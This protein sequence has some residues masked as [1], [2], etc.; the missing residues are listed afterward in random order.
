MGRVIVLHLARMVLVTTAGVVLAPVALGAEQAGAVDG[1]SILRNA[2]SDSNEVWI[3]P[4]A[5]RDSI[6]TFWQGL[7]DTWLQPMPDDLFDFGL[8]QVTIDSLTTVG[9]QVVADMLAG[10]LWKFSFHPLRRFAFNRVEGLRPG[11]LVRL[12]KLGRHRPELALGLGYG[13]ASDRLVYDGALDLPLVARQPA[14]AIGRPTASSWPLLA[15]AVKGGWTTRMFAGDSRGIRMVTAFQSGRDPNYY[16]RRTGGTAELILRPW[17]NLSLRG[18]VLREDHGSLTVATN[19]NLFGKSENVLP[20]LAIDGLQTKALTAGLQWR[21]RRW[22]VGGSVQWHRVFGGEL[23][24]R[25]VPEGA[26]PPEHADFRFLRLSLQG[27]IIDRFGTEYLLRGGW[28]AFDRQAPTQWKT[29]LGDYRSLRGYRVREMA[30][31]QAGWASLDI[32]WGF[33]LFRALRVPLLSKLGLQPIT[34]FDYGRAIALDGPL[35]NPWQEGWRTDAGFGL[36]KLLG[37]SGQKG[38][39]RLYVGRPV[40]RGDEHRDWR[41]I[42][43]F[44]N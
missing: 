11:G 28:T 24:D 42:L 18:G 4:E 7:D 41:I 10:R 17:R 32:R 1:T 43:A 44:E 12:R 30:G 9:D 26:S 20:N 15:L 35:P 37:V 6:G 22:Q 33:D 39:L 14:D 25:L 8:D 40:F 2:T 29:Y 3:T 27:S 23:L 34:Y 19:W 16:Y 38:I 31:D 36:G 5:A 13:I 21:W